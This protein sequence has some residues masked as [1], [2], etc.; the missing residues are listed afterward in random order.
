M[1]SHRGKAG[2]KTTEKKQLKSVAGVGRHQ[3]AS[4]AKTSEKSHRPGTFV[5][6]DPRINR[7][8]PGPG[9]PRGKFARKCRKVLNNPRTWRAVRTV[10][11]NPDNPAM[12]GMWAEVANRGYGR[13]G[14]AGINIDLPNNPN[15]EG[16]IET[17][18]VSAVVILMN[19][20]DQMATRKDKAAAHLKE[21]A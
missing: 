13:Q 8:K 4:L 16:E 6:G 5:P 9:R 17:N 3:S 18:Q 20:L 2:R 11:K 21:S 7:T 15:G 12:K 1:K 19:R 14:S 10:L